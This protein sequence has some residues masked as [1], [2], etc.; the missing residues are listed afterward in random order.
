MALRDRVK[1]SITPENYVSELLLSVAVTQTLH[2]RV[3]PNA[4]AL[5][6]ALEY[7][8]GSIP[9]LLDKLVETYQGGT[10]VVLHY[11]FGS[12]VSV[13]KFGDP[14]TGIP[15]KEEI[16]T[17]FESILAHVRLRPSAFS[18]SDLLNITDEITSVVKKTLYML[19][20]L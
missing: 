14:K 7:Y 13:E 6:K 3:T 8:Y 15:Q 9:D 11:Y 17:Y 16:I 5:H 4:L 20:N 18:D 10:K 19:Y 2:W 12:T 1:S